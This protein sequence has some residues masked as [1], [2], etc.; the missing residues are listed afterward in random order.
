MNNSDIRKL[1]RIDE[2]TKAYYSRHKKDN[3]FKQFKISWK[4]L[5]IYLVWR[6]GRLST[7]KIAKAYKHTTEYTANT[8]IRV[9]E[10][11]V[12][13]TIL[14]LKLMEIEDETTGPRPC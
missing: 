7:S 10:L 8:I 14:L 13:N 6:D 12:N 9:H 2:C 1:E 5:A 11:L 4:Q 3:P